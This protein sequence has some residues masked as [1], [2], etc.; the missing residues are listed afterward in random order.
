[1]VKVVCKT[2]KMGFFEMKYNDNS[3]L[4]V[5]ETWLNLAHELVLRSSFFVLR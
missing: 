2:Q 4:L 1:M 3:T 5:S